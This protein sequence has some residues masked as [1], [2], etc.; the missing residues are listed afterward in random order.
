MRH[1]QIESTIAAVFQ[2]ATERAAWPSTDKA[3]LPNSTS[4][5][6]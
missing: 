2:K 6:F 3:L 5:S 1:F 4:E